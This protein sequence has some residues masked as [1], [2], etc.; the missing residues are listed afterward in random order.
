MAITR[1]P[2]PKSPSAKKLRLTDGILIFLP[3]IKFHFMFILFFFKDLLSLV[4]FLKPFQAWNANYCCNGKTRF[5]SELQKMLLHFNLNLLVL[6]LWVSFGTSRQG[7]TST[8]FAL[9]LSHMYLNRSFQ[10]IISNNYFHNWSD[11]IYIFLFFKQVFLIKNY[12]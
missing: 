10:T 5:Y 9:K 8:I 2:H 11:Y 12:K 4:C 7:L 6:F 1:Q 3:Q